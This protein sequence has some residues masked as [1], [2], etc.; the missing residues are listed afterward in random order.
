[1]GRLCPI[2]SRRRK[3]L[4]CTWRMGITPWRMFR[5]AAAKA[6]VQSAVMMLPTYPSGRIRI[7]VSPVMP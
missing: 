5:A 3:S 2:S 6:V 7:R 1:M 4:V